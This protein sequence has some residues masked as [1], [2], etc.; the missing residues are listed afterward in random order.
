MK[1]RIKKVRKD[2]G[3]NQ[4]EFGQVIGAS[5]DAVATYEAG[6]V[7]PDSS[8]RMLIC[9]KFN[10]NPDWLEHG[11]DV[12]PYKA[13]LIPQLEQALRAAPAIAAALERL[14]PRMSLEDWKILNTVVEKAIQQKDEEL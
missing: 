14:M 4:T 13:G 5:R 11:G 9:E 3:L 6:R 1:D 10:V 7:I 8:K 2:A 12:E